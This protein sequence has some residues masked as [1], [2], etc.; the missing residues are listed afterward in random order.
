MNAMHDAP[1]E[2]LRRIFGYGAFRGR[3]EEV[4]RHVA[5]ETR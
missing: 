1:R 2:T 4:I 3:Q 5:A